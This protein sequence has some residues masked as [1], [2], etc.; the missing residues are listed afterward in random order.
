MLS[1][2]EIASVVSTRCKVV[3][4]TVKYVVAAMGEIMEEGNTK[5]FKKNFRESLTEYRRF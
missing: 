5:K 3:D 4:L 1:N 2:G